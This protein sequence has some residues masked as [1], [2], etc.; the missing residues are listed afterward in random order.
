M[1]S[2][3][4]LSKIQYAN[5]VSLGIFTI[6]LV[7]EVYLH[8]FD[9]IR[10]INIANFALAW[11][12]FIN[13]R[14][15]QKTVTQISTTIHKARDGQLDYRLERLSDGGEM[16][17]LGQTL[18]TFLAQLEDFADSMANSIQKASRQEGYPQIDS[19]AYK[20]EFKTN[21]KS[22]NEAV[23]RMKADTKHIAGTD[24]NDALSQIG[25]GVTGEL[26]LLET[27][28]K[29]SLE[30]IE[31]IV[32]TS[33]S[34][35]NNAQN[36]TEEMKEVSGKLD[37]LIQGVNESS[38][39]IA[40]LTQKAEEITS[41]VDL[42]K[43]IADQTNLLALNAAIEAAR[44]GEQGR[45]FAVVADE[46]RKLAE[47]TQ[48]ATSEIAISIQTLQQESS[49]LQERSEHMTG[50]AQSSGESIDAF[51]ETLETFSHDAHKSSS[52]AGNIADMVY[53]ILAKIDHTIYKSNA[54]S[55]V[56]RR[57]KQADFP[58]TANCQLG[59]WYN[60]YAKHFAHTQAYKEIDAP[61]KQIHTLVEDNLSFV[62]PKDRVVENKERILK[63]FEALE[64][65]S[66]KVYKLMEE[67]I[68]QGR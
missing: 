20:G 46:V 67:M 23:T 4:S 7:I 60:G 26:E 41:V 13:I 18:N 35:S 38:D 16:V 57:K 44:A 24:V 54:Y 53:V 55:S 25:S 56:F 48:K 10:V 19:S 37:E 65:E 17:E 28:L 27:D 1:K 43:D 3:S 42:I 14:K 58:D 63:N 51:S 29:K 33:E 47:R 52:Y 21:I 36:S 68:E 12:M 22:M 62:E 40:Q 15:V 32:Q 66:Q 61:H 8:G 39:G 59:K 30:H 34:T 2:I 64:D 6:A 45:G 49:G 9:F 5:I 11:Y 31:K 50:I